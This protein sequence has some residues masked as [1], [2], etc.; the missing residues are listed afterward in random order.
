MR[1]L[2]Q[3]KTSAVYALSSHPSLEVRVKQERHVD[4]RLHMILLS[5]ICGSRRARE[6]CNGA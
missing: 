4:G 6:S 2:S 3:K 5:G 1:R